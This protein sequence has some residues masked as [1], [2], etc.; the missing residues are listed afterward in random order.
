MFLETC[1]CL[2]THQY[3]LNTSGVLGTA[4]KKS[5]TLPLSSSSLQ[6]KMREKATMLLTTGRAKCKCPHSYKKAL[7]NLQ[8]VRDHTQWG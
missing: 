3:F 5:Q 2:L 7:W 8:T 1:K 4:P 6:S